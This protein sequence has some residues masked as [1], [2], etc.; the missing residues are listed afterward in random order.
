MISNFIPV[1]GIEVHCQLN[2]KAKMFSD[3]KHNNDDPVNTNISPIDLGLP[4]TLPTVNKFAV[5]KAIR[6]AHLLHMEI[7]H[8]LRFDRKNYFYQD[9][10]KGYQI[11]QQFYPIGKNGY[12]EIGNN[13]KIRI[14]RIH[15]EEDTAK[16][17]NVNGHI[18]LDYNRAGVPL[19]EI[20]SEPDIH[21]A[22][23]AVSYLVNLK[24][25]L[26]FMNIS[27][28][29]MEN[30]SLRA[31]I[32]VSLSIF[33]SDK[34]NQRTEIKN[35]N[36]FANIA[37]AINYEIERQSELLLLNKKIDEVTLKWNEQTKTTEFIRSKLKEDQ[38]SYQVEPNILPIKLNNQFLKE[39]IQINEKTPNEIKE[40]YAKLGVSEKMI[41]QLLDDYDLY[42]IFDYVFCSTKSINLT[43]TWIL[44]ELVSFLKNHNFSMNWVDNKKINL[45]IKLLG[46]LDSNKINGKQAKII[47]PIMLLEIKEPLIIMKEKNM[48]Q[49]TDEKV[50]TDLLNKIIDQNI[51][52]L[53]NYN[54]RSE[55]VLKFYLG[56]LMKETNGQAN[57]NIA[58]KI[59]IKLI[60]NRI[61][62]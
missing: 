56:M 13:K 19:I 61:N 49:I 25:L 62:K 27:D 11:T 42:K 29:K 21:S 12:I 47:F 34:K 57:P 59:L 43:I 36:S 4:G 6:L 18:H 50:L 45:I 5:S 20:V 22:E 37:K 38:Y 39:S 52:M 24:R 58:N 55:R 41:D 60:K 46:L 16:E 2:T 30:G 54:N 10:P 31:D 8:I 32:N 40:N 7:D 53:S 15:I 9:L 23:E 35:V 44:V 33:G 28:G 48:V 1:I 17:M 14:Q 51:N 3:A 26:V